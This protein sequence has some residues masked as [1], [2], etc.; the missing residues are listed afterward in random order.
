VPT[1]GRHQYGRFKYG[2]YILVRGGGG[3][4]ALG[5]YAQ[6]RI[7]T[8]SSDGSKSEFLIPAQER[9]S[10]PSKGLVRTRIRANDGEWVTTQN[11]TILADA[12]K[13]R[14]RS[15]SSNGT[16]SEWVYGVRGSLI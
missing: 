6:Y 15:V 5:P 9:V 7:R 4:A 16:K 12:V 1:Y 10:I 8:I 13:V 11:E 14:I 3:G 2:K